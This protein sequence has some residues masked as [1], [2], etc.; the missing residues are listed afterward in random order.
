MWADLH[1]ASEKGYSEIVKILVESGENPNI[2]DQVSQYVLYT[3]RLISVLFIIYNV[4]TGQCVCC[5]DLFTT[6]HL[7]LSCT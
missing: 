5:V 1:W 4:Y 2:C 7:L 6:I 3:E